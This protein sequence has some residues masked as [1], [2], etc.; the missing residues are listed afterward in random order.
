MYI[1]FIKRYFDVILAIIF[2]I[3]LIPIYLSVYLYLLIAIGSPVIFKDRRAGK[4][5]K[6]FI[7]FKFRTMSKKMNNDYDIEDD[8]KRVL[9]KTLFLRSSR[10]DEI[11]QLINVLKGD[12]SFVGPRPLLEEY[13]N[14]YSIKHRERLNIKP[15][16]TGWSQINIDKVK[17]WKEKFDL[18][19][20][21]IN[22][23]SL[24]LDLKIIFYTFIF[25]LK[26]IFLKKNYNN[27]I[28]SEKFNGKN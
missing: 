2:L 18:D 3:L 7:L 20:W 16:I 13:N 9:N 6:S 27:N 28:F 23:I 1:K 11:P 22:N 24:S 17:S 4:N 21:Y 8:R 19:I 26:S 15:G 12:I 14:I 5:G 25:L 10:L